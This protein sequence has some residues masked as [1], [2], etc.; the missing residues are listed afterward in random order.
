[1]PAG[2]A[3]RCRPTPAQLLRVT[4]FHGIPAG[5]LGRLHGVARAAQEGRLDAGHLLKLGPEEAMV[6]EPAQS[7]TKPDGRRRRIRDTVATGTAAP[8]RAETVRG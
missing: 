8:R 6:R 7:D 2:P 5:R 3:A 1:V 4:S